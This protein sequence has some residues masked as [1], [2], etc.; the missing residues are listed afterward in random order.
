MNSHIAAKTLLRHAAVSSLRFLGFRFAGSKR[1]L[2]D[3]CTGI[4]Q[5][6]ES[7]G[8]F[9]IRD[10]QAFHGQGGIM[11]AFGIL[12]IAEIKVPLGF[13][14]QLAES[15]HLFLVQFPGFDR[16][17]KSILKSREAVTDLGFP[18][19]DL[20][21]DLAYTGGDRLAASMALGALVQDR[22]AAQRADHMMVMILNAALCG[23]LRHMAVRAG[24]DGGMPALE[25]GLQF[26]MLR[27]E[28]LGSR[29]GLLPVGEAHRVVIGQDRFGCHFLDAVVGHHG[30]AVFRRKVILDMALSAG[31]R[32][33]VNR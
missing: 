26:R 4:R 13:P 25:I 31:K 24:E 6:P 33:G 20:C 16:R 3:L 11:R 32:S 12:D 28:H 7:L 19:G 21:L 5:E 15:L 23:C 27:L 9:S 8:E 17:G 1:F 14:V 30:L 2:T 10:I 29:T 22:L 18:T